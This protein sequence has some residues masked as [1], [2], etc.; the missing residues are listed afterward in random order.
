M[1]AKDKAAVLVPVFNEAAHLGDFLRR[2]KAQGLAILVVDDGSTDRS[3]EAARAEGVEVLAL[4]TNQGKGAALAAGFRNLVER[5]FEWVVVL[6]GDGQHRPE[7]IPLFLEKA[8]AG[9]FGVINGS[10]LKNPAEMPRVRFL[11]NRFMSWVIGGLAGQRI[12]DSQCGYK[13][14]SSAFLRKAALRSR[15]FEIESEIL[16]EAG[17]LGFPIGA[18][19]VSSVYGSEES[20]IRPVRDTLR[21]IRFVVRRVWVCYTCPQRKAKMLSKSIDKTLVLVPLVL[22]LAGCSRDADIRQHDA[23]VHEL[24]DAGRFEEAIP[25]AEKALRLTEKRFGA[26]DPALFTPLHNLA[27]LYRRTG[28]LEQSEPLYERIV[29]ILERT[30]GPEDPDTLQSLEE[31]APVYLGRRKFAEAELAVRR[32]IEATEKAP[33]ASDVK[34]ADA[35]NNLAYLYLIQKRYRDA[36]PLFLKSLDKLEQ[37]VGELHESTDVTLS[38]L[39]YLYRLERR[40]DDAIRVGERLAGLRE[41]RTGADSPELGS[42]FN[43]LAILYRGAG[44]PEEAEKRYAKALAIFEKTPERARDLT[45]TA[46]NYA[47][48]LAE[49][50]KDEEAAKLRERFG[51]GVPAAPAPK[52]DGTQ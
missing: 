33:G 34:L 9:P 31:L 27:G 5:G 15:R 26:D 40:F 8:A 49:M 6:D 42:A 45:V 52:T 11:T 4:G 48:L 51:L 14:L 23:R 2:L 17:R 16:L 41:K 25:E 1:I 46:A 35:W 38:H 22:A 28:R 47:A 21:F 20:H 39:S 44:R 7:E 30:K 18:V 32:I 19:P 37:S 13:M 10:R 3:R 36:E 24:F 29:K 12:E 43:N 50:G